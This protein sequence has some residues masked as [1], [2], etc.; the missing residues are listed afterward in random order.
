MSAELDAL[1]AK[2]D[3]ILALIQPPP[4]T[5]PFTITEFAK[6]VGLSRWTIQKRIKENRIITKGGRIPP[7]ELRKFGI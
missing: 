6:R 5:T 1:H 2:L 4:Q 7:S 3:R